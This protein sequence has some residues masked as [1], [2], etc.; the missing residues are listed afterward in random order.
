MQVYRDTVPGHTTAER[1]AA[2]ARA[3]DQFKKHGGSWVA[4]HGFSTEFN[5]DKFGPL[6]EIARGA[7]LEPWA[8]Y[9]IDSSDMRGKARRIGAVLRM[10]E[11]AGGILDGEEKLEDESAAAEEKHARELRVEFRGGT[12]DDGTKV[13]GTAPDAV[14]I[15][16][17]WELPAGHPRMPYREL[18]TL[19][20]G[21]SPM[22]YLNNWSSKYG[23]KRAEVMEPKWR[24]GEQWLR[25]KI[26]PLAPPF[27]RSTH[28]VGW[29][30]IPDEL[31]ASIARHAK[32][33]LIWSEPFPGADVLAA[34]K[35]AVAGDASG[36]AS[37]PR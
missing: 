21:W 11:C 14:I 9:G 3:C 25:A 26:A 6:A 1:R 19:A 22:Q 8:A 24:A 5:P 13:K 35:R 36:K 7:E 30:D 20:D 18:A 12:H 32:R 16:Q 29:S 23:K 17:S 27:F 15:V 33:L 2:C 34:I 37:A 28:A 31:D 4:W 10:P